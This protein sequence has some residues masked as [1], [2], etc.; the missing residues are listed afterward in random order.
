[1]AKEETFWVTN[2]CKRNVSLADLNLTIPAFRSINLLDK[3]HYSYTIAQLQKSHKDGSLFNKRDIIKVRQVPPVAIKANMPFLRET[4]IQSRERSVLVIKEQ[5][6]EELDVSDVDQKKKEEEY[7]NSN[8]EL[9]EMDEIK[10]II[11]KG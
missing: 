1:M 5:H 11:N 10:P 7:A 9:A 6:Y 8:A 4:F 3:K 2:I